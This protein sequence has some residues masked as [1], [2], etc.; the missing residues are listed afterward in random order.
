[1]VPGI[2]QDEGRTHVRPACIQHGGGYKPAG[3]RGAEGVGDSC[4]N[5]IPGGGAWRG[6]CGQVFLARDRGAILALRSSSTFAPVTKNMLLI[7]FVI[8][9]IVVML[10]NLK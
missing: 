10:E 7:R 4:N 6:C 1:M 5:G 9:I 3:P 2:R 8:G